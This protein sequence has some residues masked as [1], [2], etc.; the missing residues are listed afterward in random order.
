MVLDEFVEGGV[1]SCR[2]KAGSPTCSYVDIDSMLIEINPLWNTSFH[3]HTEHSHGAFPML[4][5]LGFSCRGAGSCFSPQLPG[6]A[7]TLSG[8]ETGH[9]GLWLAREEPHWMRDDSNSFMT[10]GIFQTWQEWT[11]IFRFCRWNWKSVL[12]LLNII[13]CKNLKAMFRW[14][15]TSLCW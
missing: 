7:S 11:C 10:R 6:L 13:I 3:H 2:M 9:L 12:S 15:V 8:A 4:V 14:R 1:F 5:F